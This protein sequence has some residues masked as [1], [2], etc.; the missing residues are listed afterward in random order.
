[1]ATNTKAELGRVLTFRVSRGDAGLVAAA[2][3]VEGSDVSAFVRSV[4]LPQVRRRLAAV[5]GGARDL[6]G[7]EK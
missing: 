2:A 7:V 6:E 4:V 5:L 3:A 1:M